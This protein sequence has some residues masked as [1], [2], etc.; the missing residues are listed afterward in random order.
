VVQEDDAG[1]AR[2]GEVCSQEQWEQAQQDTGGKELADGSSVS[3]HTSQVVDGQRC[4]LILHGLTGYGKQNPPQVLNLWETEAL[5]LA[6]RIKVLRNRSP[7][8]LELP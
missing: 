5:V 3:S 1:R 8:P 4:V 6:Q 7:L 2:A